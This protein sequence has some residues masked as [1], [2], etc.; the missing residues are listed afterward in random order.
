M[1]GPGGFKDPSALAQNA[2]GL[3]VIGIVR[4]EYGDVA[5]SMLGVVPRE[6]RSTEGGGGDVV[7]KVPGEAWVIL[8]GVSGAD[9]SSLFGAISR[10]KE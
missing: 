4:G 5:M 7:V 8:Q 6:K 2:P 9:K 1:T 10:D 3:M